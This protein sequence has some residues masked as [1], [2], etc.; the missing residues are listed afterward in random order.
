MVIT[1]V[2]VVLFPAQ[3]NDKTRDQPFVMT[4]VAK[5]LGITWG[6]TFLND[7][8]LLFTQRSGQAG[9]LTFPMGKITWLSGL[10]EVYA[11]RQGGLLD[12]KAAPDY[13]R[14]GWI[15]FTYS[16]PT[17]T[18]AV[19]TLARA[20]LSADKLVDWQ[21]LLVTQSESSQDIHFGSRIAFDHQGHVFFSVGDRGSRGKAQELSNHAGTIIRM[22]MD[23]SIPKDN[24]FVGNTSALD[25][26]W[27]YGH[28]NPQGL[29]FDVNTN[30]LWEMEHGPRGGDEIN[31]IEKGLN[32]GWPLVSQGK[33]YFSGSPVGER[34]KAGMIEPVKVYI[35]S[36]APSDLLVYQGD[37][38]PNWQGSLFSGALVLRHLNQVTLDK[39]GKAV[40]EQRYLESLDQRVRSLAQD[41][42]GR[43]YVATDNGV[44]YRL[45]EPS[46]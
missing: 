22:N 17:F 9:L 4:P 2:S 21:D 41:K 6:M 38:F 29:V 8:T 1:L 20:K 27:S 26:I 7:T 5:G 11:E 43:I 13:A 42:Q 44:I 37:E 3:A 25:E 14:T 28:R 30:R 33:E 35:P 15:Y 24:P 40:T 23:G 10:P 18:S 31:L 32:Y 39:D 16:K 45:S 19:T 36:I 34:Y 12:V 46:L